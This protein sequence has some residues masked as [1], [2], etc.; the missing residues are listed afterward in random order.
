MS[1]ALAQA[2]EALHRGEVPV[3]AV[4]AGADGT[5]LAERHDEREAR[6]DP[7]AHA[8][9]LALR[10]AGERLGTW[11]LSGCT[12]VVTLEP[13]PM[14][15]GALVQARIS[16]LLYGA[17]SDK[18]GSC[19]SRIDLLEPGLFNH[20]VSP[21]GG[22]LADECAALLAEFFRRQRGDS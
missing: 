9:I 3:G 8:E 15:A 16:R 10:A 1:R 12:L 11:N 5:L 22:L 13:C 19:G 18:S 21:R 20:T 7:T 2:E 14:C 6:R 4:V 17:L